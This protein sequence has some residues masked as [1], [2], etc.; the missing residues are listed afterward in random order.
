MIAITMHSHT[1]HWS[2]KNSVNELRSTFTN[3][4]LVM[5]WRVMDL[6]VTF[7]KIFCLDK[8]LI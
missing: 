3:R 2:Q 7:R 1:Y 5:P 8:I 6:N 4:L